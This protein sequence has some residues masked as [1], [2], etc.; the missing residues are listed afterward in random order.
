[1]LTAVQ[2]ELLALRGMRAASMVV[3]GGC[4]AG[5]MAVYLHCDARH[6]GALPRGQR[7]VPPG[8]ARGVPQHVV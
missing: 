4:S 2:Q 7:L 1:M 5:G 8:A 6:K 3:V